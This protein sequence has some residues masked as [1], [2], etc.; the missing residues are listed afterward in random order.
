[1]DARRARD[2][3][4][5]E[6]EAVQTPSHS[7]AASSTSLLRRTLAFTKPYLGVLSAAIAFSTLYSLG[8]VA[9]AYLTQPLLDEA[10]A[11]QDLDRFLELVAYG[12]LVVIV[13]P[14]GVFGR[15]YLT[16]Y[17]LGKVLLDVRT[18]LAAKLLRLPLARHD[19]VNTGDT[20]TRT[21]MDANQAQRVCRLVYYELLQSTIMVV[22]GVSTMLYL[23]WKLTLITVA[24]LPLMA[25]VLSFFARRVRKRAAKRQRQLSE[26]T[27][28]LATILSGIKVIKAFRGEGV[29][30]Q[31]FFRAAHLFFERQIKVVLQGTLSRSVVE[32]L[33]SGTATAVVLIGGYLVMSGTW[34]LTVGTLTAFLMSGVLTYAPTKKI[35]R[36][37]PELMEALASAERFFEILDEPEDEADRANARPMTALE[38]EVRFDDVSFSYGRGADAPVVL[39]NVSFAAGRGEVVAIVGR[40]GSGKTTLADLLLRFYEPTSG[41]ISID[42]TDV[43]DLQRESFLDQIAV[44][45]QE[46]FLFDTTIRENILYGRP[47]ADEAAFDA[48]VRTAHVDEFVD[49]LPERYE[50]EVGEFGVMLS[51]GQRQ[52]ITIA[53]ALLKDP[54]ILVF[55]EATS[56]LDAKTERIVQDAL[57]ALRGR[58]TVFVIAHRLSTIRRADR[59]L[60]LDEGR[61]VQ[62]GKHD[63][64]MAQGGLYREF[65]ALQAEEAD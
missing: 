47:E 65:V 44:V 16:K 33:N 61:I 38:R 37:W 23:S 57:D 24:S 41:A 60:V 27:G 2:E 6:S 31:S 22:V 10:I 40:T 17:A 26:V 13:M 5:L 63:E 48:A 54:S 25:G 59:I 49:Q 34:G 46:P 55:D 7:S 8:N 3:E 12:A 30:N 64:L 56:A 11:N 62:Q 39:R 43:R 15:S 58:R 19:S 29:E 51:G 42:G 45:T 21:L 4:R 36:S 52:R 35:S 50:T 9:R 20:L 28:R 32:F 53:R 14:I 1:M 18:A